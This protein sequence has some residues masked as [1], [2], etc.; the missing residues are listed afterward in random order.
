MCDL[1]RDMSGFGGSDVCS[2]CPVTSRRCWAQETCQAHSFTLMP[3]FC[4]V[5]NEALVMG[6]SE[7]PK[8]TYGV[9]LQQNDHYMHITSGIRTMTPGHVVDQP[10][11]LSAVK[12]PSMYGN[13][14][15]FC[16]SVIKY[17][18][19]SQLSLTRERCPTSH[20]PLCLTQQHGT[21][22]RWGWMTY[23]QTGPD[24]AG[25]GKRVDRLSTD[26]PL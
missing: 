5:W 6:T 14:M 15:Y 10:S 21:R 7:Q 9:Y 16:Y 25:N 23:W 22:S 13:G 17:W 1:V 24:A 12:P 19:G 3:A 26:G 8:L 20:S 2:A 18:T 4:R 11:T